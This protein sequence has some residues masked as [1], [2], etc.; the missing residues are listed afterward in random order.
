M[1]PLRT[2]VEADP[3]RYVDAYRVRVS[4]ER[5]RETDALLEL[6][7]GD[8]AGTFALHVRRG[9]VDFVATADDYARAPDVRV[10]LTPAL[11]ARVFDDEVDPAEAVRDGRIR[12]L[13][14]SAERAAEI[15]SLFDPV[16]DWKNDTALQMLRRRLPRSYP[17]PG[18]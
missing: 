17:G 18:R 3:G 9:V 15:F 8:D 16:Y 7:F 12:V 13:A 11:W 10:E 5:A 4:P 14:G 6:H 1:P 2:W